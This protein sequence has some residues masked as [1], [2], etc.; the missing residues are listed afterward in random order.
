MGRR[1]KGHRDLAP[2]K[3]GGMPEERRSHPETII[4]LERK[5]FISQVCSGALNYDCCAPAPG[6]PLDKQC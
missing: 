4:Q 1:S 2:L 5:P 3:V 6:D